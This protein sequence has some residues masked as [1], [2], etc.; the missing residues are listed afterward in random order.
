MHT[1]TDI[2]VI[3]VDYVFV[4]KQILHNLGEVENIYITLQQICSEI[5]IKNY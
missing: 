4:L 2:V 1:S 3:N 5:G